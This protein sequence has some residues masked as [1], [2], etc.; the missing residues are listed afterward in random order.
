MNEMRD[1]HIMSPEPRILGFL[2]HWCAYE[3][4]DAAGR[5]R[6]EVPSGL[7]IVR[8]LCS[9]RVDPRHVLEAFAAG[10]DGVLILGCRVGECHYRDG[11]VQAMKRV[12]LL[13]RILG[14][15]GIEPER[16]M[17]AWVAAG[18]A[19]RFAGVTAGMVQTLQS[20]GPLRRT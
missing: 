1:L 8:V 11:N 9:G 20:L 18:E 5:K 14:P 17:L 12:A 10:A 19:E 2:C 3:G 15:L 16:L 4:A 13:R 7:R 6:L